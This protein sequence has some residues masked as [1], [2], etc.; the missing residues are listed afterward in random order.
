MEQVESR[1]SKVKLACDRIYDRAHTICLVGDRQYR[2]I[3]LNSFQEAFLFSKS[4][5]RRGESG[6]STR[7]VVSN[8]I[9]SFQRGK[10]LL[11]RSGYK[12]ESSEFKVRGQIFLAIG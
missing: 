12:P 7:H 10:A 2:V 5:Q 3:I 11:R 4:V 9:K 6:E 1:G 8:W